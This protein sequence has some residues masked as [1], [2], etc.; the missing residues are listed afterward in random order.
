MNTENVTSGCKRFQF[1]QKT[2][3]A[4]LGLRLTYLYIH[5]RCSWGLET[6]AL[7]K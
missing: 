3:A 4:L 1:A 6:T 2:A 7:S 5:Q